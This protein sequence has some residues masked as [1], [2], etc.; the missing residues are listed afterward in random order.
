MMKEDTRDGHMKQS[1]IRTTIAEIRL[2]LNRGISLCNEI[3][4]TIYVTTGLKL[5]FELTTKQA[6]ILAVFIFIG[7]FIIGVL[8]LDLFKLFQK[9]S[10][11]G[12]GKYN[13]YFIK[14]LGK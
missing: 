4:N 8:D 2:R 12:T 1:K 6:L 9:E 13:P 7:F 14:K 5:I 10:E 11:L 3:K